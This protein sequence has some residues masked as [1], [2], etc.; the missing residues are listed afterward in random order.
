MATPDTR[1]PASQT[2]D[3]TPETGY[4]GPA[5]LIHWTMAV[6]VLASIPVGVLMT[7]QGLDRAFQNSLYIFHKNAGVLLLI[8]IVVRIV[9]RLGHTPAPLPADLPAWQ[10]RI[11]GLSHFGLYALLLI[12]PLAGYVRVRAGGFP[13]ESL[14]AL[15]VPP[16]VPRS[17]ALAEVAQTIHYF[18]GLALGALIAMHIGAALFHGI[19]RKDGVFSRM[20]PPFKARTD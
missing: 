4:P 12:M 1:N 7:Q 14:D 11:A 3:K 17:D 5:R 13:I 10:H 2:P 8:L 18:G 6:L 9:Y 15:G 16:L 20:W 19:I